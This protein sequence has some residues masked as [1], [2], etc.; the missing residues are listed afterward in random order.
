MKKNDYCMMKPLSGEEH[1]QVSGGYV[2]PTEE[3]MEE[4]RKIYGSLAD[5][6]CWQLLSRCR[7][8]ESINFI[9]QKTII[10]FNIMDNLIKELD[11]QAQKHIS[12]GFWDWVVGTFLGGMLYDL[13]FHTGETIES[14][15]AGICNQLLL[16]SLKVISRKYGRNL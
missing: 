14:F 11:L 16:N 15:N 12:G 13:T 1:V 8:I 7:M 9:K 5:L 6:I 4:L 10:I 2:P 3:Q